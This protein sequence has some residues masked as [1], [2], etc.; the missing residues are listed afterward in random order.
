MEGI[1]YYIDCGNKD[2]YVGSTTIGL[3]IRTNK[4]RSKMKQ[5]PNRKL[6]KTLIERSLPIELI[7]YKKVIYHSKKQ[8][9]FY[10]EQARKTLKATINQIK[11][12]QTPDQRKEHKRLYMREYH[13]RKKLEKENKENNIS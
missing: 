12:F 6:Y 11:C 8:L 7:E 13:K 9:R 4:H 1:I 5:Y 10:E 2:Y 3:R